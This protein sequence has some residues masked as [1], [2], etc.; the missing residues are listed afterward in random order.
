MLP[1]LIGAVPHA[2]HYLEQVLKLEAG[3]EKSC[4]S[5]REEDLQQ[6]LAVGES[7]YGNPFIQYLRKNAG[8]PVFEYSETYHALSG[9]EQ[10]GMNSGS[11]NDLGAQG[12]EIMYVSSTKDPGVVSLLCKRRKMG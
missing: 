6:Y 7:K 5:Y 2:E 3:K 9:S 8:L 1:L 11:L 10:R 4:M 12:W